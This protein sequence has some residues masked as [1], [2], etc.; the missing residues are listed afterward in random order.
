MNHKLKNLVA[1]ASCVYVLMMGA[2]TAQAEV[3]DINQLY[4]QSG[5]IDNG[6]YGLYPF[7]TVN[8]G[9]NLV[10]GYFGAGVSQAP[11]GQHSTYIDPTA[12]ATGKFASSATNIYTAAYNLGDSLYK[13]P[14]TLVGGA[15]PSGTVN[16]VAGT[17]AVN[18]SSFFI[19]SF[20]ADYT[21]A[22]SLNNGIATG[23]W[24]PVTG[25]YTMSIVS[26]DVGGFTDGF[27]RTW[28]FSG[29]A[30]PVPEASTYGMLLVGLGCVVLITRRRKF[31]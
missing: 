10:S 6:A 3:L 15:V 21:S 23:T 14:G 29:T 16:T 31:L 27:S 30:T 26:I 8:S 20:G 5:S 4:L 12:I 13:P 2:S 19:T 11:S 28:T 18:V 22:G 7:E 25:A 17:I 9:Y 24:N 1:A